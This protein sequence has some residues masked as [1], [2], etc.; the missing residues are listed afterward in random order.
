MKKLFL[1]TALLVLGCMA[2][3]FGA[4]EEVAKEE[5]R[6]TALELVKT[7]LATSWPALALWVISEVQAFLPTQSNGIVHLLVLWLKGKAGGAALM[8]LLAVGLMTAAGCTT[9]NV[10]TNIANGDNNKPAIKTDADAKQDI[11]PNT[12]ATIPL[13]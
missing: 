10:S 5:T 12:T 4:V 13:K 11:S 7:F 3:A 2:V 1:L 6:A 8:L 9:L